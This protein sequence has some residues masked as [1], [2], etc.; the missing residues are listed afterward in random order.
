MLGRVQKRRG[1]TGIA[2]EVD[3]VCKVSR[4]AP[5]SK[6][7]ARQGRKSK[8]A[9]TEKKMKHAMTNRIRGLFLCFYNF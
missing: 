1:D 7:G 5:K 9:Q 8:D 2:A 4:A 3:A 6:D